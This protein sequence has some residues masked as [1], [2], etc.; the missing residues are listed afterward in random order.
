MFQVR[1][2]KNI[3]LIESACFI[4]QSGNP[5]NF[6][7]IIFHKSLRITTSLIFSGN[8][9]LKFQSRKKNFLTI[10]LRIFDMEIFSFDL[11]FICR[12]FEKF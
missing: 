10:N 4:S 9:I 1:E 5:K 11:H 2:I 6:N 12:K 8:I 7:I 3:K